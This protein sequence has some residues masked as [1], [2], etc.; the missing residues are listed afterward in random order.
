MK[1]T[2]LASLLVTAFVLPV[3]AQAQTQPQGQSYIGANIGESSMKLSV[4]GVGSDTDNNTAY[5]LYAGYQA[6]KNLGFEAGFVDFGKSAIG[7][8]ITRTSADTKS[9]YVAAT[10]TLPMTD[11]FSLFGKAGVAQ[12]RTRVSA[13]GDSDSDNRATV[14]FGVGAAYS[15]TPKLAVVA[16]YEDYGKVAKDDVNLKA[17]LLSVGMRYK[18]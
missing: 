7:S 10:G 13:F 16:E 15:F 5:K 2:L 9:V 14:M 11:Q 18:F 17:R 8:G 1:N 4:D 3:A 12:N 6:N